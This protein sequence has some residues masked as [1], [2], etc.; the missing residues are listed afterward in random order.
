M[1]NPQN[2]EVGDTIREG[3][4][5]GFELI[6]KY[7]SGQAVEDG[8]LFDVDL[9]VK[10]GTIPIKYITTGL[11]E[12]GYWNDTCKN[13]V[14]R[15]EVGINDR[16]A[17]CETFI[18]HQGEKLSCIVRTLNIPN[19]TDLITQALRIFS[20]KPADDWFVSG[21]VELPSGQKQKVFIVQNETGRYTLM[22]PED[23]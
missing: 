6:S 3:P 9:L 18:K 4:Y 14:G 11:L 17:S 22:L 23:Y 15:G 5:K 1:K 16:C 13:G 8:L 2:P 7:T 21:I 12:R 10:S 19:M 20:K